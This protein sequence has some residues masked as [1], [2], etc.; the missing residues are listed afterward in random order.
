MDDL[1]NAE[2]EF[3]E[4]G[5]ASQYAS[6]L[7]VDRDSEA[8]LF[9]ILS[10]LFQKGLPRHWSLQVDAKQRMF[11]WNELTGESSWSHPDHEVFK[12]VVDLYRLSLKQPNA[13]FFLRQVSGQLELQSRQEEKDWDGPYTTETGHQYWHN[14]A[15]D[16]S[17]WQDPVMELRR[18]HAVRAE[19]VQALLRDAEKSA[20]KR[21]AEKNA[22]KAQPASGSE[23]A[24]L[25]SIQQL[26]WHQEYQQEQ[27][28]QLQELQLKQLEHQKLQLEMQ[29][30]QQQLEMQKQQQQFAMLLEQQRQANVHQ[31]SQLQQQEHSLVQQVE[32]SQ[33]P[34]LSESPQFQRQA[35][36]SESQ[37]HSEA[38]QQVKPKKRTKE[39]WQKRW[40]LPEVKLDESFTS[41]KLDDSS[42]SV[43]SHVRQARQEK[44]ACESHPRAIQ[45]TEQPME[46]ETEEQQ[47]QKQNKEL[48]GPEKH[49]QQEEEDQDKQRKKHNNQEEVEANMNQ[50]EVADKINEHQAQDVD[51]RHKVQEK[52]NQQLTKQEQDASKQAT[53]Q[54]ESKQQ[55]DKMTKK[56]QQEQENKEQQVQDSFEKQRS[57]VQLEEAQNERKLEST[58][59]EQAKNRELALQ[60][61]KRK[62][63]ARKVQK[64]WRVHR[65][66][67]QDRFL[68]EQAEIAQQVANWRLQRT[69][70]AV[71]LQ[72]AWHRIQETRR[73]KRQ[74][75]ELL[76]QRRQAKLHARRG[77]GALQI[78]SWWRAVEATRRCKVIRAERV[79]R[80]RRSDAEQRREE[81]ALVLQSFWRKCLNYRRRE[82][83]EAKFQAERRRAAAQDLLSSVP[84][85][86]DL[87]SGPPEATQS[88]LD[89]EIVTTP[90]NQAADVARKAARRRRGLQSA[91]G[92]A[93][94]EDRG[95]SAGSA[96][97]PSEGSCLF[98]L[99]EKPSDEADIDFRDSWR[100]KESKADELDSLEKLARGFGA[101]H[102]KGAPS[103]GSTH[104]GGS[105][106]S[107]LPSG[108]TTTSTMPRT[109]ACPGEGPLFS[110]PTKPRLMQQVGGQLARNLNSQQSFQTR[111]TPD[112]SFTSPGP[113]RSAASSPGTTAFERPASKESSLGLRSAISSPGTSS[114]DPVAHGQPAWPRV[115]GTLQL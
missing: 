38:Q 52:I 113:P 27:L 73:L 57:Q 3:K 64:A 34:E 90:V 81:A 114:Y 80:Q 98:S 77:Q 51:D 86:L 115:H 111:S 42:S 97:P 61:L 56:D 11:F 2:A 63:F 50:Q 25:L 20:A 22:A 36:T 100:I 75:R 30:Q 103:M 107:W 72:K 44:E 49:N 66:A 89:L 37:P 106:E 41:S 68:K 35:E 47:D 13:S 55:A 87:Q 1:T 112:L 46:E 4:R 69:S 19:S 24:E 33:R 7:E 43:Q 95:G 76:R 62:S 5:W 8:P 31:Q 53:E 45:P 83:E 67:K 74:G 15:L 16:K 105:M 104:S 59:A 108:L 79:A 32:A 48:E 39:D 40:Q 94:P 70:A 54:E 99:E 65:R 109:P 26:Q 101:S 58:T 88:G 91:W 28:R 21:E 82:R 14:A 10:D 78:Q 18:R 60:R 92:D 102:G 9:D 85:K 23:K 71:K 93:S 84:T 12:A 17:V 96:P 110:S 6:I 29:T